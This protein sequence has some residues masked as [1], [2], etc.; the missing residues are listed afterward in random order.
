MKDDGQLKCKI[1]SRL[2]SGILLSLIGKS[3]LERIVG[4]DSLKQEGN[5]A[6][7]AAGSN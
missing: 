4:V 1:K 5:E 2:F 3:V 7:A 6:L